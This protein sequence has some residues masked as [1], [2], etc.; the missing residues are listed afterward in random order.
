MAAAEQGETVAPAPVQLA[1]AGAAGAA[2][3]AE[4]ASVETAAGSA[5]ALAEDSDGLEVTAEELVAVDIVHPNGAGGAPLVRCHLRVIV[6][7]IR[8]PWTD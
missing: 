7:T 6:L 2:A 4:R 8:T 5:A 1:A 3:P